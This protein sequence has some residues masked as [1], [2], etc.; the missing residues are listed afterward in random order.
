MNKKPEYLLLDTEFVREKTYFSKLCL[1]QVS[2]PGIEPTIIDPL[3]PTTEMEPLLEALNDPDVIKV[4][5]SAYQDLEIFYHLTGK[6]PAPIFDTQV[7]ASVLG[8]G[9][10]TSY[11]NLCKSICDQD[12]S[13]AQQF[14]DWSIRPL[15]QAQIDYALGDVIYLKDIYLD[16]KQRLKDRGREEWIAEDV[17]KLENPDNYHVHPEKTWEKI[18]MKSDKPRHL[19]VLKEIAAWRESEAMRRNQPKNFVL[20][21]DTLMEIAM[22]MPTDGKALERVRG[23]QAGQINKAMGQA[24]LA[25]VDKTTKAD[26]DTLPKRPRRKSF[27]PHKAGVLEML[28]LLLK[29]EAA[30]HDITPRRIADNDHLQDIA[31]HGEKADVPAMKGWRFDIFGSKCV[32][33]M[34]GR[35]GLSVKDG[36]I[37]MSKVE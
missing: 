27:P 28:K 37:E 3:D 15:S 1:V 23:F 14:T 6:V 9:E 4:L 8:Y 32:D 36:E 10:Q 33:L 25:A 35:V 11:A 31:L 2:G 5:H 30:H 17:A 13:K 7:A 16:L 18:K 20:R 34:E 19:G 21:D 29:I 24:M 12:I 22:T 26:P